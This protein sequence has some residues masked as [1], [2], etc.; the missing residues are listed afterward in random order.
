MIQ[1]IEK[2]VTHRH[3]QLI[4]SVAHTVSDMLLTTYSSIIW[5]SITV[6]KPGA[7]K[8]TRSVAVKIERG[9]YQ[10]KK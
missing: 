7:V 5:L 3:Y 8:N 6:D 10:Y 1:A 9:K 4:E 2:Q